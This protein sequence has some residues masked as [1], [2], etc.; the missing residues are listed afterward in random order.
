[1]T[2][3]EIRN[4]EA[5]NYGYAVAG[6]CIE[7]GYI[8]DAFER[9]AE[10]ADAHPAN[11]WHKTSEELPEELKYVENTMQGRREWTESEQVLVINNHYQKSVDYTKNG[12][13]VRLRNL[14]KDCDGLKTCYLYWMPIPKIK[15]D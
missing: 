9:G 6:G 10:W 11:P 13:W 3:K 15:E 5:T 1:M 4:N 12:E 7:R 2:R 14:P 8:Q